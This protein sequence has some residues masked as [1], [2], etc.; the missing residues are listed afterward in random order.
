VTRYRDRL[1]AVKPRYRELNSPLWDA[2]DGAERR[3]SVL[4]EM[5]KALRAIAEGNLGDE[6]WQAN[7]ERIREVA[8]AALRECA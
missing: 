3:E 2:L 5:E 4:A 1:R 6:G 8:R 7:Y